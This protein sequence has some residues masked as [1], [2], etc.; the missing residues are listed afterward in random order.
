MGKL[1]CPT[2]TQKA[3]L[4]V[5]FVSGS[6]PVYSGLGKAGEVYADTVKQGGI[7]AISRD[8][9]KREIKTVDWVVLRS[10]CL[11]ERVFPNKE[12][13]SILHN[14]GQEGPLQ[15]QGQWRHVYQPPYKGLG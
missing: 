14:S 8:G 3:E 15:I 5:D 10:P 6:T 9:V 7:W 4:R 13:L 12:N 2:T 11:S 1:L